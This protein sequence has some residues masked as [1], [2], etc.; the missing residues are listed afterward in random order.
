MG[1]AFFNSPACTQLQERIGEIWG[2]SLADDLIP[3]AAEDT[4][5]GLKLSGLTAKPGIGRSTRRELVTLVNRRPVDSRLL[6]CAVFDAYHGRIQKGRYPPAFLFL[7][8]PSDAVDVNVP[9][10][11]RG[12]LPP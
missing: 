12:A 7:S 11:A 4:Q 2:R 3:I 1:A 5:I 8:M 6:G 10:Q 9:R